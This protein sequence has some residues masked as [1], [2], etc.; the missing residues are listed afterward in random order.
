M[1][2]ADMT[3][4][5]SVGGYFVRVQVPFPAFILDT[6][7]SL[8][9]CNGLEN[10]HTERYRGFK[11]LSVRQKRCSKPSLESAPFFRTVRLYFCKVS[12]R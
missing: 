10:R 1:E 8:V 2:S 12:T 3:D 6:W 4:L 5:K 7:Q 11:S 9:Y